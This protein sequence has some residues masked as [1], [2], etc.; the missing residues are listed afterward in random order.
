MVTTSQV[1]GSGT[2]N[3]DIR[4]NEVPLNWKNCRARLLLERALHCGDIPRD[5]KDMGPRAVFDK[6][7]DHPDFRGMVYDATF[8]RRLRDLRK[9]Q[10]KSIEPTKEVHIDWKNSAA[11]QVLKDYFKQ[12]TIP[13]NYCDKHGVGFRYIWDTYCK[14]HPAFVGME[15]DETFNRRLRSV[16]DDYV[17][18]DERAEK[19]LDAFLTFIKNHPRPSHN[20]RGEPQ[21]DGSDAQRLLKEDMAIRKNLQYAKP[22]DFHDSRPEYGFYGKDCFRQHIHQEKRLIK[23]N[24]FVTHKRQEKLDKQ[25]EQQRKQQQK[26]Q[27]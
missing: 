5:S 3:N 15:C 26:Q 8:G 14:N 1:A 16:R 24:N 4:N 21:W 25:Q 27:R 18:K 11:K 2:N 10:G 9:Q 6:F 17:R 23:F 22:S 13:L 19:D 12:K 7:K 20:H